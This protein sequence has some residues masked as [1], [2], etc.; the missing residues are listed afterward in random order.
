MS[1]DAPPHGTAAPLRPASR[2]SLAWRL[3]SAAVFL[4]LLYFLITIGSWPFQVF[5]FLL[6]ILGAFEWE[7]LLKSRGLKP[8]PGWT[9]IAALGFLAGACYAGGEGM[10]V[11]LALLLL[12]G[13]VLELI[14]GSM[15]PLLL[16]GSTLLGGLYT[17]LLP[18]FFYKIRILSTVEFPEMGRDAVLLIFLVVWG[19]DTFAYTFGRLFGR[20]KLWPRVSPKK[21]WEGAVGGA[22][23][24]ILMALLGKVWFAGFLDTEQAVVFGIIG[25]TVSQVGDL[26]ES[27]LK[28]EAGM[29]DSS[30]LIPGHGGILDRFDSL[31][32]S[33]PI[34]YLY[35]LLLVSGGGR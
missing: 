19:C 3:V 30:S 8:W 23:G 34:L 26:A 9:A 11:V 20:H 32:F 7:Q 6:V 10:A 5:I 25:G 14:C 4:P 13:F 22:A 29:K 12:A 28:R 27:L 16:L 24:A 1:A 2:S 17:G 15:R 21:S 31:L 18:A 35:L 33:L